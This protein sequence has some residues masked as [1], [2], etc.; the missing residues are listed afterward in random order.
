MCVGLVAH[1]SRTHPATDE[2]NF[3]FSRFSSRFYTNITY[4]TDVFVLSLNK[5]ISIYIFILVGERKKTCLIFARP[6]QPLFSVVSRPDFDKVTM[7]KHRD[8]S[9]KEPTNII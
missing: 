8:A 7:E 5:N 4:S 2:F 1:P 3:F 6:M 9:G